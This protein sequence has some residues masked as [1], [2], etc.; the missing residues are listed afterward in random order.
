MLS[1]SHISKAIFT[2]VGLQTSNAYNFLFLQLSDRGA[3]LAHTMSRD[4][5]DILSV[6]SRNWKETVKRQCGCA[7]LIRK[8]EKKRIKRNVHVKIKRKRRIKDKMGTSNKLH[9]C[10]DATFDTAIR[11]LC[12]NFLVYPFFLLYHR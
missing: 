9:S 6:F 5:C 11:Q 4:G 3:P 7:Y 8:T 10:L 12:C 1:L 2:I